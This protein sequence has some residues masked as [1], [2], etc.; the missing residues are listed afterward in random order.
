MS[1]DSKTE[2]DDLL[3]HEK[4]ISELYHNNQKQK[5]EEPSLQLDTEILATA[6]QQM[7]ENSSPM[8]KRAKVGQPDNVLKH[9]QPKIR[10]TWRGPFSLVASVC[11]LSIL[12]ITQK[13][14]FMHPHHLD[15][16]HVGKLD[17]PILGTPTISS[18]DSY[19]ENDESAQSSSPKKISLSVTKDKVILEKKY[20]EVARQSMSI[21]ES[22]QAPKERLLERTMLVDNFANI[23]SLSLHELSKLAEELKLELAK[24]DQ[25]TLEVSAKITKMQ[26]DLFEHL[27]QHQKQQG[28]IK[29]TE[30][31]LNLLTDKQIKQLQSQTIETVP[32]N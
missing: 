24:N 21:S 31:F 11:V 17:G 10:N 5:G 25:S 1:S 3:A 13:D 30:E 6:Q 28:E 9:R 4:K 27:F 2:S 15:G 8:I 18:A 23:S 32:N 14:Y 22:P 26:Q 16:N 7:S 29:L 19:I 20:P 12:M